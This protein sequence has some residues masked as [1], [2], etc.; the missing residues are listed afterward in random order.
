MTLKKAGIS[1]LFAK[2]VI[3]FPARTSYFDVFFMFFFK[4]LEIDAN[5]NFDGNEIIMAK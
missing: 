3:L 4:A 2:V 1:L 5:Q